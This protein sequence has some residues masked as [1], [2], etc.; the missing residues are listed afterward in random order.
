MRKYGQ[1]LS[2]IIF[3]NIAIIITVG[4]IRELF[5]IY[6]WWYNDQILLLVN[7]IYNE[8]LPILL[9]YTG[10]KLIGG[11]R[12]AVVA[13]MVSY[14]LVLSS[15][16]PAILGTM[17]VGP[18]TGWLV[19]K[20]DQLVKRKIPVG[21]ELLVANVIAAI[22]G[23]SLTIVSFLY[24]GQMM[25][26]LVKE[27]TNGL[28]EIVYAGWL[29]LTATIIEPAKVFFFNNIINFGL[30][31]PLGIQQAK[32]LGKSIFFLLES[33]P[34]PGLGILL[35][36]WFKTQQ[37]KRK[38]AKLATFI[39]MFGGIHEVYFPYVLLRPILLV[40][41]ICGGVV[42]IT[43]FQIFDVGLVSIPSP[44][45]IL[46][47]VGLAPKEDIVF[48]LLGVFLSSLVSFLISMFMLD[49]DSE[50]PSE[51]ENIEHV[52]EFEHLGEID[53]I[54]GG[55]T[56]HTTVKEKTMAGA[57]I[58]LHD[59]IEKIQ[60]PPIKKIIF[61][62]E[63]GMGS[64]AMGAALL[65]KKLSQSQIMIEVDNSAI[66]KIPDDTD[67]IICHEKLL[68]NVQHAKPNKIYFPLTSFTDMKRYD[69]LIMLLK[70]T[71]DP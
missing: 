37:E 36:Y 39:H 46:L 34:G 62:C 28:E 66:D 21:Y 68:S 64:S 69:Q 44:G 19:H 17:I 63:A 45:S 35:A 41:V 58:H 32:E 59:D 20:I 26:K 8:L 71:I 24:V 27:M 23:G 29:P 50:S 1:L 9:G 56:V 5:G 61:A 14:G 10:G 6:G 38:G 3:Q 65:R 47:L 11:H 57:T 7:P 22:I 51:K 55:K 18:I 12:G 52:A 13:S 60:L 40:A 53:N 25:S 31:G 48:L 43:F 54:V 70:K 16:V 15:S 4:I 67:L 42:G 49:S 2:A 33:N 30:L